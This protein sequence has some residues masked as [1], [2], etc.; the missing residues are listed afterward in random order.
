MLKLCPECFT[1]NN[2]NICTLCGYPLDNKKR[3]TKN[4]DFFFDCIDLINSGQYET[5][6]KSIIEKLKTE[7]NNEF[8]MLIDKIE[9][10]NTIEANAEMLSKKALELFLSGNQND[11]IEKIDKA[12]A[13]NPLP[14]FIELKTLIE[15]EIQTINKQTESEEAF[16]KAITFIEKNDFKLGI[17]ILQKISNEFPDNKIYENELSNARKKFATHI[18]PIIDELIDKKDLS[19]AEFYIEEIK[20]FISSSEDVNHLYNIEQRIKKEK[21]EIIKRKNIFKTLKIITVFVLIGLSIMLFL[22]YKSD[23][24]Q[25]LNIQKNES[26]ISYKK[27]ISENQNS[28]FIDEANIALNNLLIKDNELWSDAINPI[29]K[30]K[31][32][33]YIET[34]TKLGGSNLDD[35][36]KKL[37]SLDWIGATLSNDINLYKNYIK[38]HPIGAYVKEANQAISRGVDDQEKIIIKNLLSKYYSDVSENNIE[39][40][41]MNYENI[42]QFFEGQKDILKEDLRNIFSY[43]L[44]PNQTKSYVVSYNTITYDKQENGNINVGFFCDISEKSVNYDYY[45]N[46]PEE[47]QTLT[48]VKINITL[49]TNLKIISF[50]S[51][52]INPF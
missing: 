2:K 23:K 48:K 6:K 43:S 52:P 39:S 42:T 4:D 22:I 17:E 34:M 25:W 13:F 40:V 1:I 14:N 50:S 15:N 8:S 45:E 3:G 33:E 7:D 12:I 47:I 51:S 5:A 35:A 27:F 10:I 37:D 32:T 20:N 38:I 16:F 19:T 11:A 28:Y 31:I 41:L 9:E 29:S 18:L 44:N 26:I 24:D 30:L 36:N 49:N 46:N 21:K